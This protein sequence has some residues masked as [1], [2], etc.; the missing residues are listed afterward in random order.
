MENQKRED[1]FLLKSIESED[2]EVSSAEIGSEADGTDKITQGLKVAYD[3]GN[4][5]L[6]QGWR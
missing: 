5:L 2:E 4:G 3:R 1:R 6:S